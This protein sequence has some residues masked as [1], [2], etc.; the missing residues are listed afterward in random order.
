MHATE[1]ARA[2][3][4]ALPK[5]G[6]AAP[7]EYSQI[8]EAFAEAGSPEACLDLTGIAADDALSRN[9]LKTDMGGGLL[10]TGVLFVLAG[11]R[12]GTWTTATLILVSCYLLV[13]SVSVVVDG[14]TPLALL[15]IA[16]E[17]VAV[18]ALLAA[19]RLEPAAEGS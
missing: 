3:L 1:R 5:S 2:M 17:A 13:R 12:G 14:P 19:R 10:G 8:L 16:A 11:L 9:M 18:A 7:H 4:E 6:Q 15:A